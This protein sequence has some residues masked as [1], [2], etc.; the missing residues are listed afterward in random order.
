[1]G[2]VGGGA[3]HL[4]KGFKS[5]PTGFRFKGALEVSR[6]IMYL[7][8]VDERLG[9][10]CMAKNGSLGSVCFGATLTAPG[11]RLDKE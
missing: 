11:T 2:C 3:W 9:S 6:W 10:S 7:Y 5:S 8:D 1:M 4:V